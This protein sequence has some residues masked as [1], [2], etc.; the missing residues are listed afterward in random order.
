MKSDIFQNIL[1]QSK[2]SRKL[3]LIEENKT[4]NDF[5]VNT[6]LFFNFFK[7]ISKKKETICVCSGYSLNFVSLIFAAY[8]NRNTITLINPNASQNEKK[9]VINNSSSSIIFFEKDYL[10]FKKKNNIFLNF[11][12]VS[13]NK[14]NRIK[15]NNIRFIIYTSGTINKAKG[16]LLSNDAILS[17]IRGIAKNLKL[18][19]K[20]RGIIFSPPAYAMGISQMLT[21]MYA[22]NS[23][24]FYNHG[25]RFPRELINKIKNNKL[26]ILNISISAFR[27]IQSYLKKNEKFKNLRLVMS[28]GMQFSEIDFKFYKKFFPN[29]KFINFYG[30]TENSPRISHYYINSKKNYNGFFPV[31]KPIH[32]VKIKIKKDFL[33]KSKMGTILV[34]GKSLMSGYLKLEKLNKIKIKNGWFNTGDL[35]FFDK[36]NDLYL[37]GRNDNTFRVGHEKVCPE[38]IESMIQKKFKI[39]EIAIVKIKDKI[40]NWVPICVIVK[41]NKKMNIPVKNILNEIQNS[42][43]S[44]KTPKKIIFLKKVPKTNYGK[45]NRSKL[46]DQVARYCG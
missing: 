37:V 19:K 11:K 23:I 15:Y 26:S 24:I 12:F 45:I 21:F 1:K 44:Y 46:Q 30:C 2:N 10:N 17:N 3:F 6:L 28:G 41:K 38:E 39:R 13:L 14:K 42:F 18:K 5:Y 31:G 25:I 43:S 16:V 34:S 35:G 22:Q 9:H 32:G 4:Y 27:I 33:K 29:A 7:K 40:L 20:D 36:N 8:L